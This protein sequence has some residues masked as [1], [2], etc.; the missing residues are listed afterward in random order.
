M[1]NGASIILI[2]LLIGQFDFRD[3]PISNEAWIREIK[4]PEQ[5]A[6]NKASRKVNQS[7][8]FFLQFYN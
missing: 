3:G 1:N 2:T 7:T 6:F 8:I 5:K 4:W